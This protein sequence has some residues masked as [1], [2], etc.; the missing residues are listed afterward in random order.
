MSKK[1]Q[2]K[3]TQPIINTLIIRPPQRNTSDVAFWRRA[4]QSADFGRFNQLFDLY[5]DLLIDGV[6]ADAHGKRIEAV[7]NAE[8]IFQDAKGENV[9]EIASLME[10]L[11]WEV[12]LREIAEPISWGRSGMEFDF[13][14]GFGVSPIPKKHISLE[15][16]SIL[17]SETDEKGVSYI[18]NDNLLVLGRRADWGLFLKTAPFVIWKRGGFGDWAQWLEIFGMPQRVGK[19]NTYDPQ[20]RILL[21]EALDKAGSAPWCVIPDGSSVETV[22]NTGSGS[23]GVSY[24]DFRKSCNE[25]ILIT[26]LGQTLTT[27]Q[28][29]K[30]ARS[31]GEVHKEVE[32]GKN[33]AD[34][35]YVEKVLNTHVKPRLEKRGY[36][37]SGGKFVFPAA[38]ESLSVN[39]VVS[40]SG[41]LRVP[42]RY[43]YDK[44]GI[45]VPKDDEEVAG[46]IQQPADTSNSTKPIEKQPKE[47]EKKEE[48]EIKQDDRAYLLKLFDR[49]C[50]FFVPAPTQRSGANRNFTQRL[51]D[52]ITGRKTVILADDY[53]I[54]IN[55][56]I[57]E[58]IR[59]IYG[60]RGDQLINK[61]LF[62]ITNTPL[63]QAIDTSL[64]V[65]ND[66]DPLFVKR[67]KENTAVFAA[68]KNHKQTAEIAALLYD[69][70][71]KIKPFYKFKKEALL[72]SKDYNIAWLQ[73]EYNTALRA[74]RM[75]AK[76]LQYKKT[77]HLYPN[78]EY[79][80]TTAMH[81]RSVHLSYVGTILPIEHEWWEDH[82]P[83]SEWNCSC[84]IR[85]T[86]KPETAVPDE[87]PT[88]P[89][90]RNNPAKTASP[91]N[92][93]ETAYYKQTS[94]DKREE[95]KDLS[96]RLLRVANQKDKEVYV[97]KNGGFLEIVQQGKV[98]KEKN[99]TTYKL[100]ADLGGKYSLLQEIDEQ[101]VSNP[102]AFNHTTGQFSDAKHPT[103]SN[104]QNAI[105]NSIRAAGKQGVGEVIIRFEKE[106]PS[107][108]L[109]KGLKGALQIGRA[110]ELQ[111]IILIRKNKEPLVFDVQKLRERFWGNKQRRTP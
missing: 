104:G 12:M 51:K 2:I 37:V 95:I 92:I 68:F 58:A 79:I 61:H 38:A 53:G 24:N 101:H 109:Y 21:E 67:F 7:T 10:T 72:V 1:A 94:P 4:L 103:T 97:G 16:Q 26:M 55:H 57:N 42:T 106:Y 60:N 98:E 5:E 108:E 9:D 102:D 32:E 40:L 105:Q 73:T 89:V 33:K 69:E 47:T 36:P 31:L 62:D 30:G 64:E 82:L 45:P 59:E 25:E 54:D 84:S 29:D 35:R 70:N 107:V 71:G 23:S 49:M 96:A 76:L 78:L 46:K 48:K 34:M 8:L 6:L 81:P 110:E 18:G 13:S 87:E 77:A 93:E 43:L 111:T 90:F 80:E 27:I 91:V 50:D 41:I 83:P 99:L 66:T 19:Y 52:S 17:L 85:P 28:G 11:D 56:L 39:D 100:L 74:A 44:Y 20:S 22:S 86:D 75:A 88:N 3:N 65:I 14:S 15:T 63:Q